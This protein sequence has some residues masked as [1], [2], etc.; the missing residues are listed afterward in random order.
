MWRLRIGSQ[1]PLPMKNPLSVAITSNETGCRVSL[2]AA[3]QQV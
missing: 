1:F 2:A 3:V